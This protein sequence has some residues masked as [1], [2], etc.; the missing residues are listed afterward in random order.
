MS[1]LAVYKL[2]DQRGSMRAA[3]TESVCQTHPEA[4]GLGELFYTIDRR[5]RNGIDELVRCF[6]LLPVDVPETMICLP[7]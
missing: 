6:Q 3:T 1:P 7:N 2:N 4:S 5:F